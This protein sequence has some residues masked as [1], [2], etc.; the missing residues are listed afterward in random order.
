MIVFCDRKLRNYIEEPG[1][2]DWTDVLGAF[3][4]VSTG[5]CIA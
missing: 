5:D 2:K 1:K 3:G 4:V